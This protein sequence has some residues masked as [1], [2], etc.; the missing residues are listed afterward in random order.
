MS[1]DDY[2]RRDVIEEIVKRLDDKLDLI[3]EQTSEAN[4]RLRKA[5]G[6]IT[7][8]KA[9]W[10]MINFAIATGLAYLGLKS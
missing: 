1:F 8:I 10:G 9:I 4:G 2:V 5:E 7:R 3:L 6:E